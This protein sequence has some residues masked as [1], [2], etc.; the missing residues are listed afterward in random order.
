MSVPVRYRYNSELKPFRFKASHVEILNLKHALWSNGFTD[1][2]PK[3]QLRLEQGSAL[4]NTLKRIDKII[5]HKKPEILSSSGKPIEIPED[6][7]KLS[8]RVHNKHLAEDFPK[9]RTYEYCMLSF[10]NDTLIKR[11]NNEGIYGAIKIDDIDDK[12]CTVDITVEMGDIIFSR[13]VGTQPIFA[14]S[15]N[16]IS[17]DID[18]ITIEEE[19]NRIRDALRSFSFSEEEPGSH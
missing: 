3:L 7:T 17:L 13:R 8:V 4:T 18:T 5:L 14:V 9:V 16:I 10:T 19:R 15:Y 6:E 1:G 12:K 11:L 2:L